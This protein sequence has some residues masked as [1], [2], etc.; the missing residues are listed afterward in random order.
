MP[1]AP[2]TLKDGQCYLMDTGRIWRVT[3][4]LPGRVRYQQRPADRPWR[5]A[6]TDIVD[7][8]SFA[9]MVERS[10]PCDWTPETDE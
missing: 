10:V 2:D 5:G 3:E 6:K 7:I 4:L 1:V 9:F 8:R